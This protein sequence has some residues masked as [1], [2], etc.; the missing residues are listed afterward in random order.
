MKQLIFVFCLEVVSNL[1]YSQN[2]MVIDIE[3]GTINGVDARYLTDDFCIKTYGKPSDSQKMIPSGKHFKYYNLGLFFNFDDGINTK[4][5]SIRIDVNDEEKYV[6]NFLKVGQLIP[7]FSGVVTI[8]DFKKQ[9]TK[10][11]MDITEH[12]LV[13]SATLTIYS[14]FNSNKIFVS[15]DKITG[16][17]DFFYIYFH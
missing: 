7:N 17:V 13:D 11:K 9:F 5:K 6:K 12:R 15:Y 4:I 3:K 14:N 1:L 16:I 8:S 2:K 10:N